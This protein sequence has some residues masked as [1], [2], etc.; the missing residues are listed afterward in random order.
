MYSNNSFY[1]ESV[2]VPTASL[3]AVQCMDDVTKANGVS[4]ELA[5][6]ILNLVKLD[7]QVELTCKG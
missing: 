5:T 3:V 1:H 4:F 2:R 6:K 7:L